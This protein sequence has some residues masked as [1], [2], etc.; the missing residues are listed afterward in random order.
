KDG[1]ISGDLTGWTRLMLSLVARTARANIERIDALQDIEAQWRRATS[2]FRRD[3]AVHRLVDLALTRPAFTLN[4]ALRD[5]G[6]TVPSVNTAARR[7]VDAGI[8]GV[9]HDARRERIFEATA[10]LDLFDRFRRR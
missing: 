10:V 8:L 7:L 4:D 3:S 6:G 5:I 1:R 2:H 9:P